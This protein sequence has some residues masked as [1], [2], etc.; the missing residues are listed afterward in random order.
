M[1]QAWKNA[2]YEYIQRKQRIKSDYEMSRLFYV[3]A[4][5]AKKRLH[6]FFNA[7]MND[8]NELRVESGSFL[9]KIWPQWEKHQAEIL[10]IINEDKSSGISTFQQAVK[11]MKS[12]SVNPVREF[13]S[14][15]PRHASKAIWIFTAGL[16]GRLIEPSRIVSCKLFLNLV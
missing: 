16:Y 2:L 13:I 15:K 3:A 12:A 5:R 4:T 7:T 8:K 6:L 1:Q 10:T 14:E 11:R 9:A